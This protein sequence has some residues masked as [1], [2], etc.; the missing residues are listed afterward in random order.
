MQNPLITTADNVYIAE[1]DIYLSLNDYI[2]FIATF[3]KRSAL[4]QVAKYIIHCNITL[5]LSYLS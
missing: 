1:Y 2:S 5:G 3:K 4:I